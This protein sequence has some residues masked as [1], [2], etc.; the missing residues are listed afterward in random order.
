MLQG[1]DHTRIFVTFK[2][3]EQRLDPELFLDPKADT[4]ACTYDIVAYHSA[5]FQDWMMDVLPHVPILW[6]STHLNPKLPLSRIL[7]YKRAS[8]TLYCKRDARLFTIAWLLCD[9]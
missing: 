4:W 1:M 7:R 3:V 6:D 9:K 5:D 2:E 8:F